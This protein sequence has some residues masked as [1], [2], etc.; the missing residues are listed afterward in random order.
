MKNKI[1]IATLTLLFVLPFSSECELSCGQGINNQ[2][3]QSIENNTT[4]KQ[5]IEIEPA[6]YDCQKVAE[7]TGWDLEISKYFVSE[8]ENR[9]VLI[10]DEALPIISKETGS[11]Y[12]FNLVHY[13]TNGTKDVGIFQINDI[14]KQDIV[15]LL[16]VE[17]REF[18]SWSRLNPEFNIS[19]GLYWM[20]YLKGKGLKNNALFTSY[21]RGINGA[22]NYAS[23]NGTYVSRYSR[24]VIKARNEINN[25]I[26]K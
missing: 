2:Y 9:G 1:I 21:N 26:N 16:E 5:Q 14:T 4:Q 3:N 11:T 12:D 18:D 8:A 7:I 6:I 22:K 17:G 20:S 25:V 10:F 15:R 23:R 13:N 19:G 24:D